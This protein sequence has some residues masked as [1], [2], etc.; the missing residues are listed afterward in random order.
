MKK[1]LKILLADDHLIIRNGLTLMLNQQKTFH[2]EISEANDGNEVIELI[3]NSSEPFDIIIMDI[4]MPE[5]DGITTTKYLTNKYKGIKIL[6]LSMH[7][8]DYLVQQMLNAGAMG[9]L[10]K[11]AGIEELTK[12][13]Q[14][15]LRSKKYFSNDIAQLLL[16]NN[17]TKISNNESTN[18]PQKLLTVREKEI[19]KL[20]A[21]ELT[22]SE[23]SKKLQI[24]I[25]TIDGHRRHIIKKLN[26][27]TTIGLAKYALV[28]NIIK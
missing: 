15:I 14:T 13:I 1:K 6:A 28:H 4:N 18:K 23:I 12:A 22:T 21:D 2:V 24:S 7:S 5:K 27:K 9:Y 8:E 10:L 17:S 25:R 3:E 11:N 20:I 19:L 16:R 26:I